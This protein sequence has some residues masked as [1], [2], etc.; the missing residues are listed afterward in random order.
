MRL[1]GRVGAVA[2]GIALGLISISGVAQAQTSANIGYLGESGFT[3]PLFTGSGAFINTGAGPV[4]ATNYSGNTDP[5]GNGQNGNT[6]IV[7][8]IVDPVIYFNSLSFVNLSGDTLLSVTFRLP[9]FGTPGQLGFVDPT[10]L[11]LPATGFGSN[12][13]AFTVTYV[14]PIGT[15]SGDYMTFNGQPLYSAIHFSKNV[16]TAEIA[17]LGVGNFSLYGAFPAPTTPGGLSFFM[18]ISASAANGTTTPNAPGTPGPKI[19]VNISAPEPATFAL[20][21]LGIVAGLFIARRRS[22]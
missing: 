17:D 8:P 16:G 11:G 18:D 22:C 13:Q 4:I 7:T 1:L 10:A 15:Y 12:G 14:D 6:I 3:N 21:G 20:A 9:T 19:M 5:I 2:F